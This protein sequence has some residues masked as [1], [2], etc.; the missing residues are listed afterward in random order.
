MENH[1]RHF[2]EI[3]QMM[4]H[5]LITSRLIKQ[6]ELLVHMSRNQIEI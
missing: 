3:K 2:V 5:R 4:C 6:A 1:N